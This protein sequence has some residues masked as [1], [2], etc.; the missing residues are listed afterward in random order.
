[1]IVQ[2]SLT[3]AYLMTKEDKPLSKSQF[4]DLSMKCLNHT[5]THTLNRIRTITKVLCKKNK[6]IG[7]YNGKGLISLLLPEDFIYEQKNNAHPTE[8]IVKIYRGVLYEGAID[9]NILGSCFNSIIQVLLKEYGKEIASDFVSNVQFITNGWLLIYGFSIGL[10]DCL[11]NSP[12]SV[13]HIQDKITKCYL[14]ADGIAE[15]TRNKGVKEVRVTA[16]LN[17]AKDIG[18]K[19]AKE[20]MK[21]TN[22]FLSTVISGSKG[23]FFNISQV[24]GLL[25]QQNLLGGR[26]IPTMN[27]GTRSLPHYPFEKLPTEIRYESEGFVE[28]SFIK[29]LTPQQFFFHAMSG[30]ENVCDTAMG[31]SRSGYTQ[32]RIVKVDEDIQAKYDGTVRDTVGNVYQLAYGNEGFD[33]IETVQVD[34]KQQPCNI[35]RMID[36][37]NLQHELEEEEDDDEKSEE[38]RREILLKKL[39]K[40]TGRKQIY[41]KWSIDEISQRLEA[42][43][44]E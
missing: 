42:L 27:H 33:P 38:E 44:I 10:E 40:K 35:S 8:P 6:N 30:R 7:P 18:M 1:V 28:N 25:G 19:I 29:G 37:L 11:V 2:D 16:A 15:T 31:T 26:V 12:N 22:N 32:R 24:T 39:I 41:R 20:S 34:G 14:E 13:L 43:E 23:D 5:S 17:K 21:T 3:G 36:R 4:F 9:K